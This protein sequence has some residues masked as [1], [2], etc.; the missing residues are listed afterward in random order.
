MSSDPQFTWVVS[1]RAGAQVLM[2]HSS[3]YPLFDFLLSQEAPPKQ[4]EFPGAR[5]GE[6]S[7]LNPHNLRF[8]TFATSFVI[9]MRCTS[10]ASNKVDEELVGELFRGFSDYYLPGQF[11]NSSVDRTPGPARAHAGF[12]LKTRPKAW[13]RP[14]QAGPPGLTHKPGTTLMLLS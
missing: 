2:L 11:D 5:H 9:G 13:A 12:F 1:A 7:G 10:Q 8:A 14:A 3:L 4:R 6:G